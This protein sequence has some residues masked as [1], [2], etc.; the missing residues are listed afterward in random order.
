MQEI[1]ESEREMMND[2]EKKHSER[3]SCWNGEGEVKLKLQLELQSSTFHFIFQPQFSQTRVPGL[4]NY[5]IGYVA[6]ITTALFFF[7]LFLSI[8]SLHKTFDYCIMI[9]KKIN[10]LW[11]SSFSLK[12]N[13]KLLKIYNLL[14]F[15]LIVEI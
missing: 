3:E 13:I 1:R 8:Y 4:E 11:N 2:L 12:V 9:I 5:T 10:S 7:P 14:V 15:F 6:G